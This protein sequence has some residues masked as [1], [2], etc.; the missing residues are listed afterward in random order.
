MWEL[1]QVVGDAPSETMGEYD[2]EDEALAA[3]QEAVDFSVALYTIRRDG[4]DVWTNESG[5]FQ[6]I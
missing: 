5:S 6:R 4:T 3:A 2:T 1:V